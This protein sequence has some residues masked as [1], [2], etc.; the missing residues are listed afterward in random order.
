MGYRKISDTWRQADPQAP[1]GENAICPATTATTA[2]SHQSEVA[3][4]GMTQPQVGKVSRVS[5]L[6][7][8]P[9][10]ISGE[11]HHKT[12][13]A[14]GP[15]GQGPQ[16]ADR[17]TQ[18]TPQKPRPVD[19]AAPGKFIDA[20]DRPTD[21]PEQGYYGRK[22]RENAVSSAKADGGSGDFSW[23]PGDVESLCRRHRR[24]QLLHGEDYAD[25][26]LKLCLEFL[27]PHQAKAE[28]KRIKQM[29]QSL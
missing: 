27:P 11:G 13:G 18:K 4:G 5:R 16:P 24:D 15:N 8:A 20:K 12:S 3:A 25:Y 6:S 29:A 26:G 22:S 10:A 14:L 23:Q 21:D 1:P 2:T 19:R 17:A 28:F 9:P 7:V